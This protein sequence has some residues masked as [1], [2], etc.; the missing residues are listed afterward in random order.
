MI[1]ET[2]VKV[3]VNGRPESGKDTFVDFCVAHLALKGVHGKKGSS[4]DNVKEAAM[5]L[6]WDGIKDEKGRKFLSDL[7]DISTLFYDGSMQYMAQVM[8]G[9]TAK[10][11]FFFIREPEEIAKFCR[12]YP[13]THTLLVTRP[14]ALTYANT[15]D[16][17]TDDYTYDEIVDNHS[18]LDHFQL[19]AKCYI[20]KLILP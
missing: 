19:A 14:G 18:T 17:R 5:I 3:I 8:K 4:V 16:S 12:V 6:G 1:I 15:G 7:K 9:T 20:N 2:L 11:I 13:E 10:V